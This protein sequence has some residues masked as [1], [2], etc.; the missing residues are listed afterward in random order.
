MFGPTTPLLSPAFHGPRCFL[1]WCHTAWSNTA[2][3]EELYAANAAKITQ[4]AFM[5]AARDRSE[6]ACSEAL[7]AVTGALAVRSSD[8][9]TS[10]GGQVGGRTPRLTAHKGLPPAPPGSARRAA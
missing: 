1:T 7:A 5:A 4:A 8:A 3:L 2:N 9:F 6:A 10:F